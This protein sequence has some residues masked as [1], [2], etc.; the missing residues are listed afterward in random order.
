M[1]DKVDIDK[2]KELE[3]ATE[4]ESKV[5]VSDD[6][7]ELDKF[8]KDGKQPDGGVDRML[9]DEADK[10]NA[11][12]E[13]EGK[14]KSKEDKT[15]KKDDKSQDKETPIP[16]EVRKRLNIPEKFKT[17]EAVAKSQ[18]EAEILA[19]R[20]QS[21]TDEVK[22]ISAKI[23][24]RLAKME[25][26]FS[27]VEIVNED[28]VAE[29]QMTE[30]R[31]AIEKEKMRYLM[32]EDPAAAFELMKKQLREEG[33]TES[34][35]RQAEQKRI[36]DAEEVAKKNKQYEDEFA[37]I[38]KE[39]VDN[40]KEE[41][42]KTKIVPELARIGNLEPG[43]LS[44]KSIYQLYKASRYD[45]EEKNKADV[46]AKKK[47]KVKAGAETSVSTGEEDKDE[48]EDSKKYDK[49][50]TREELDKLAGLSEDD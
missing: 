17:W 48:N 46:E 3:D 30:E 1:A 10:I 5:E 6:P 43:I 49:A 19:T 44:V 16:D 41:E 18:R 2:L 26:M 42:F 35:K 9:D 28:K 34:Q 25:E 32:Q 20:K 7:N 12:I 36:K 4:I 27:Q 45:Q 14:E 50:K 29:G 13:A 11:E 31:K 33:A 21:E 22:K 38:Q 15:E 47:E 39:Y 23:E 40:G 8:I 24:E 37:E